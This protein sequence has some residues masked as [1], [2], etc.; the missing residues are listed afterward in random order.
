MGERRRRGR[1]GEVIGWDI[2]CLDR[3]DGSFCCRRNPLLQGTHVR[4][5]RRLI[6]DCRRNSPEQGRHLGAG[7]RESKDVV[8]EKKNILTLITKILGNRETGEPNPGARP[9]RLVHLP[10]HQCAF[11]TCDRPVVFFRVFVYARLDHLVVK[12]ISFAGAFSYSGEYGISAV[13]LRH[14]VDQFHNR[15]GFADP[16]A[17]KQAHLSTTGVRCEEINDLEASDQNLRLGRLIDVF[18]SRLVYLP[19]LLMYYWT[20]F[21]DRI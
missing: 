15:H 12:I 16:G 21:V 2:D 9:R 11:G 8:D 10:I 13:S 7:L 3:S 14:V 5:K 20:R 4:R 6:S 1:V 18:W 17:S 19:P